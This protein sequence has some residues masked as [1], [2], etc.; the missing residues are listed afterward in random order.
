MTLEYVLRMYPQSS[1]PALRGSARAQR[2]N[3]EEMP[4]LRAQQFVLAKILDE[5]M[6][7]SLISKTTI[8]WIMS[9]PGLMAILLDE[10]RD[11]THDK[12]L[13]SIFD[14]LDCADFKLQ[15]FN[16]ATAILGLPSPPLQIEAWE[17]AVRCAHICKGLA[18][19]IGYSEDVAYLAGL[20]HN[21]ESHIAT[22]Q[23]QQPY[24]QPSYSRISGWLANYPRW[25]VVASAIETQ[26]ESRERLRD[27]LPLA[28]MLRVARAL[29]YSEGEAHLLASELLSEI[30]PDVLENTRSRAEKSVLKLKQ[31]CG[32]LGNE[33]SPGKD[34]RTMKE[35]LAASLETFALGEKATELVSSSQN[36]VQAIEA[37]REFLER[38]LH[39]RNPLF[40]K[41][42]KTSNSLSPASNQPG[43]YN[44]LHIRIKES[45][46]AAA[47]AMSSRMPVLFSALDP[48]SVSVLDLQLANQSGRSNVMALPIG[49]YEID[50]VIVG[51]I[52]ARQASFLE[53]NIGF[54][55]QLGRLIGRHLV[56]RQYPVESP[57]ETANLMN[58]VRRAIHEINNPLGIVKNY[59]ALLRTKL[60]ENSPGLDEI[61]VINEELDRIPDILELLNQ[62]AQ[63]IFAKAETVDINTVLQDMAIL[64]ESAIPEGK[65][66][67]ISLLFEQGLPLVNTNGRVLKQLLLNLLLNALD[68]SPDNGQI[69]ME[70][71]RSVDLGQENRIAI[72]I[73]DNGPGL[74][75]D[76]L[77]NLFDVADSSKG[78][79]HAGLGLSI[80]K[81]LASELG[82][83]ISCQSNTNGT[84]F[85]LFFRLAS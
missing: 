53:E 3:L 77:A 45:N 68:A 52:S 25:S 12:S 24:Q 65:Q 48:D 42:D 1:T 49:D 69:I 67:R 64:A 66:I 14:H 27:A 13:N 40:L 54:L 33:M 4:A 80:V 57:S 7:N 75:P 74:P 29:V 11:S 60:G 43:D 70:S 22:A 83:S 18:G 20:F 10:T 32:L 39:V 81:S 15:I 79:Q 72:L 56:E 31:G 30:S 23:A 41:F 63:D 76:K 61:R 8:S 17:N 26:N 85:Q 35:R 55:S 58:K 46:T 16:L 37:T 21:L 38:Y 59:L 9:D 6:G 5:L 28:K 36:E 51:C 50:G 82:I 73:K 19:T 62:N 2:C 34:Q 71:C 47:W 84:V 78:D 44:G